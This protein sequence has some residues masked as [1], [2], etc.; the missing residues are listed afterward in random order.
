MID[1]F[2]SNRF[3]EFAEV[4]IIDVRSREDI[5]AAWED[6][7]FSHH[8]GI[9]EEFR[10]SWIYRHFR[11]SADAFAMATLQCHPVPENSPEGITSVQELRQFASGLQQEESNDAKFWVDEPNP[12]GA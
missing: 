11:R 8:Y 4:E 1:T 3:Y 7:F 10:Y 9:F 5:E 12:F 2:S 6:F